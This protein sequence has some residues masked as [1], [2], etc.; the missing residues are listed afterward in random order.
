MNQ[1]FW[2]GLYPGIRPEILEY[3]LD[4]LHGVASM[5]VR[6]GV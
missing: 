3:M 1:V 4:G 5:A 6:A 2:I